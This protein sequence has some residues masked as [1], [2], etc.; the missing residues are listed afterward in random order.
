[1]EEAERPAIDVR[2]EEGRPRVFRI[3][4]AS[5]HAALANTQDAVCAYLGDDFTD[6]D[7]FRAIRPHG[8]GVLV[9]EEPRK[10]EAD[11]WL[12]RPH[13]VTAFL[14]RWT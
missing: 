8:P 13:E 6:E 5:V 7:A 14:Q 10:T 4:G 3:A 12:S 9:R 2:V 1:M 11:L